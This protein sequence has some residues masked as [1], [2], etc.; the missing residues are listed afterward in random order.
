MAHQVRL[1]QCYAGSYY[2]AHRLGNHEQVANRFIHCRYNANAQDKRQARRQAFEAWETTI[3]N[4]ML[5]R[6]ST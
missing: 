5:D 3:G 4:S 2:T 1:F 6:L